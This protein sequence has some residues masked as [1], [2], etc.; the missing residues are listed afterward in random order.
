[1]ETTATEASRRSRAR[2]TWFGVRSQPADSF[3]VDLS[4]RILKREGLTDFDED[5]GDDFE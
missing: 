2:K 1:M 5:S 4:R 3:D